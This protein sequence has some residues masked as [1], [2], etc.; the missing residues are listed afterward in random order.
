MFFSCSTIKRK[1]NGAAFFRIED[2]E[3]QETRAIALCSDRSIRVACCP[4]HF[5]ACWMILFDDFGSYGLGVTFGGRSNTDP[6]SIHS[7]WGQYRAHKDCEG[8]EG[9]L[10]LDFEFGI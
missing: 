8:D 3:D 4:R 5:L 9:F 2:R 10:H 7:G 1:L 6:S